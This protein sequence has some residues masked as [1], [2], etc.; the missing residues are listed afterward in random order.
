MPKGV[1]AGE[2]R[3]EVARR[4]AGSNKGAN[5]NS[6]PP[7]R[8]PQLRGQRLHP[9]RQPGR[10]QRPSEQPSSN[11]PRSSRPCNNKSPPLR[12]RPLQPDCGPAELR[13]PLYS[14]SKLH[15]SR[16]SRKPRPSWRRSKVIPPSMRCRYS[17]KIPWFWH[18]CNGRRCWKRRC[19]KT[20]LCNRLFFRRNSR[21]CC[22][23]RLPT[24]QTCAPLTA[25]PGARNSFHALSNS[26][27]RGPGSKS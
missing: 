13:Q 26:R 4:R 2:R 7:L 6:R 22:K 21:A 17:S 14:N 24:S 1:A 8:R 9:R 12:D 15:F 16:H 23:L 18:C 25:E 27:A 11:K 20:Q 10:H 5:A 3:A 19:S